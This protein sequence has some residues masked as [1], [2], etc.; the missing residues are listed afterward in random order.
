MHPPI[1]V[2]EPSDAE[3]ARLEAALRAPNAFTVRRAQIVLAS[4]EGRPPRAIACDLRCAVQAVRNGI[5]AFNA[6][7]LTAQAA[8]SSRPKR[9]ARRGPRASP[10]CW[11]RPSWSSSAA[12]HPA[13]VAAHLRPAQEHLDAR[14][15]G[16][17]RA[18][19]GAERHPPAGRDDPTGAAAA[20][21]GLEAGRALADQPRP[22][23]R[24][25]ESRRD[26]LIRLTGSRPGWALGFADE[27]WFSRLAQPALHAWTAGEALRLDL[28]RA[29]RRPHRP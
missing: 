22:G 26:R 17:G 3:R 20:G 28:Q 23:L 11:T 29:P 7:G 6:T 14:P 4:A 8:G 2:R 27:V 12:R 10:R 18:R 1:L 15:P 5:R 24:S 25:Q 9:P 19:A 16:A 21:G 13:P